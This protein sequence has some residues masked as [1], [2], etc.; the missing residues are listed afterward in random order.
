MIANHLRDTSEESYNI[1]KK[2][3]VVLDK[4][5]EEM[6]KNI[7]KVN[8]FFHIQIDKLYVANHCYY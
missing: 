1:L 3:N 2:D 7:D 8:I 4:V 5:D 6:D